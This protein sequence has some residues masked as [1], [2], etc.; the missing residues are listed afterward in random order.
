MPGTI[1]IDS[2]TIMALAVDSAKWIIKDILQNLRRVEEALSVVGLLYLGNVSVAA[3]WDLL[4]GVRIHLWPRLFRRNF[5]KEYGAWAVIA[6][7]EDGMGRGYAEVL[8]RKGMNVLLVLVTHGDLEDFAQEIRD[9]YGVEV[10]IMDVNI[11]GGELN[12]DDVR[13]KF[14]RKEIGVLVNNITGMNANTA[15][16]CGAA[17][18][19]LWR[20]VGVG[21][22][23]V[24]TITSLVL[25]AMVGRQKGAVVNVCS[26]MATLSLTRLHVYT[27]AK[28]FLI[29]Y[30]EVLRYTHR[31]Q[32]IVVQTVLPAE[33]PH[34]MMQYHGAAVLHDV[35]KLVTPC[36]SVFAAHALS[37][38][39][40]ASTTSG[41]WIFGVLGWVMNCS[42]WWLVA[43]FMIARL[44]V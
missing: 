23:C 39:G 37:T 16:I 24:P 42:P 30:S 10:E 40:Y 43:S 32:G 15:I 12:C 6:G 5:V 18:P 8:A 22:A 28:Y 44:P 20:P 33:I 41:Y 21:V 36:Q 11:Y 7:A 19:D 35:Y 29:S 9:K 38:L 2:H 17:R 3:T 34:G 26:P 1:K 13:R 25:P 4:K 27:A 14:A 31:S